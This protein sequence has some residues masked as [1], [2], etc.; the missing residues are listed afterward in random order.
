MGTPAWKARH[1]ALPR[2]RWNA[3]ARQSA[4]SEREI[5]RRGPGLSLPYDSN[6]GKLERDC[7]LRRW[8]YGRALVGLPT[9]NVAGPAWLDARFPNPVFR[10]PAFMAIDRR[11]DELDAPCAIIR[12]RWQR[13]IPHECHRP[14]RLELQ[15]DLCCRDQQY[16]PALDRLWF[17]VDFSQR[18]TSRHRYFDQHILAGHELCTR[19]AAEFEKQ[20]HV[21]RRQGRDVDGCFRTEGRRIHSRRG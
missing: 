10:P 6:D 17:D 21:F 15:P 8:R 20:G 12:N 1:E 18:E 9:Q 2:R 16:I 14:G 13:C 5:F 4:K 11:R 3:A 19:L 7:R